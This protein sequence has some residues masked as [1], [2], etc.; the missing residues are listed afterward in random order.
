MKRDAAVCL[1]LYILLC[2]ANIFRFLHNVLGALLL[3]LPSINLQLPCPAYVIQ[4]CPAWEHT[5][6]DNYLPFLTSV[7]ST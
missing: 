7:Q 6:K 5:E 3:F 4:V 2:E 1:C